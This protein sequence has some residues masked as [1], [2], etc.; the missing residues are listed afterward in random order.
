[1]R[2]LFLHL[3]PSWSGGARLIAQAARGLAERGYSTTIVCMPASEVEHVLAGGGTEVVALSMQGG[4]I[5]RSWRL[6][7]I[8]LDR[9]VDVVFVHT[10][11][12]QRLAAFALRLG[13]RGGVVRRLAAGT[14]LLPY[15]DGGVA[16]RVAATTFLF[17]TE[18]AR[19]ESAVPLRAVASVVA[20]VG[21]DPRL[22]DGI[23]PVP[24][25][26]VG[27]SGAARLIVCVTDGTARPRVAN[28]LR[29]VALLAPRHPELR[30][31]L[32]GRGSDGEE[33]RMHAAALGIT[34]VVTHL[35]QRE[36]H[37]AV[38][39]AADIGWVTASGDDA[40]LAYLD[41]MAL[42]V[43]ILAER[44]PLAQH[45]VAD[46]IAGVLLPPAD[47]PAMA[48]IVAGYLAHDEQRTAMGNAGR[49]RVA[50]EFGE[51]EM[52]DGFA[53][54]AEAARDGRPTTP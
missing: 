50:R 44:T 38:L 53:R 17:S 37:L 15:N 3:T 18:E 5:A 31:V 43:P 9:F 1:V 46:G 16:L 8:L 35:G 51:G 14:R 28:V 40:A 13:N 19:L 4:W 21:T 36:D 32:I 7:R 23:R 2:A 39:R 25:A 33:V 30:L 34:P 10:D 11:R 49:T 45:Y 52:L 24:R 6:R 54:A 41:F 42:R 26:S 12:E 48:A 20:E 47:P 22:H 29:T 27:A